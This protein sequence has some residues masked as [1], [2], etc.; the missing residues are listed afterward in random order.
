ME[1]KMSSRF[2]LVDNYLTREDTSFYPPP[3]KV[4]K[5]GRDASN[6]VFISDFRYTSKSDS[7]YLTFKPLTVLYEGKGTLVPFGHPWKRLD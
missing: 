7:T 4:E 5:F 6:N 2:C 1:L 3:V